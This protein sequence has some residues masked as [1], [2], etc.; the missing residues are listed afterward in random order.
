MN[1][2][3]CPHCH[4]FVNANLIE[5]PNCHAFLHDDEVYE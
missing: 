1:E 3:L 5:C 4:N 2:M